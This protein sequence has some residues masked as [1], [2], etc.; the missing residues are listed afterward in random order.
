M[1]HR[2]PSGSVDLGALFAMHIR[3]A[4][5]TIPA[6]GHLRRLFRGRLLEQLRPLAGTPM[7]FRQVRSE[8]T[9]AWT[10][11]VSTFIL[12]IPNH[13]NGPR[14]SQHA[15]SARKAFCSEGTQA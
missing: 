7:P 8:L 2:K 1:K 5:I 3:G 9:A 6:N 12:A 11:Q 15:T 4:N 13:R 10:G 14:V